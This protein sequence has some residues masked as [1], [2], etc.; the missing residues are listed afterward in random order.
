MPYSPQVSAFQRLTFMGGFYNNGLSYY[1]GAD[2]AS[3][4]PI[5]AEDILARQVPQDYAYRPTLVH[6]L[7][8]EANANRSDTPISQWTPEQ[9]SLYGK[10]WE[11]P[12]GPPTGQPEKQS[13]GLPPTTEGK[14]AE[15][16]LSNIPSS[17]QRG[18]TGA[19]DFGVGVL[20]G[21]AWGGT[22]III[23]VVAIILLALAAYSI[24]LPPSARGQIAGAATRNLFA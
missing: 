8:N 13:T 3:Y 9:Q 23:I 7:S 18:I 10:I 6:L 17:V 11:G 4:F 2:P 15:D 24:I 21:M 22:N 14:A 19:P 12:S 16:I 20:K 1:S 5:I